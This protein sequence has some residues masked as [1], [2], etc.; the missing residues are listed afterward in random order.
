V[1]IVIGVT[2]T[3]EIEAVL[4]RDQSAHGVR[5]RRIHADLAVP[6]HRHEAKGRVHQLIDHAQVQAVA[7]GDAAPVAYARASERVDT[8]AQARAANDVEIDHVA[9]VLDVGIQVVMAVCGR[10]TQGARKGHAL[11]AL[12]LGFQQRVGLARDP[13]RDRRIGGAAIGG[14]VFEAAVL[15]WVV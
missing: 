13:V 12:E 8:E 1:A 9:Q 7:L 5:G 4:E 6:I 11:H 10:G 14:I 3:G 2:S 15:W